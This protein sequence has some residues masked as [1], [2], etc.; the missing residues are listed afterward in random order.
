MIVGSL[1][2]GTTGREEA[3]IITQGFL[4]ALSLETFI[5]ASTS[6]AST[7]LPCHIAPSSSVGKLLAD[8][9]RKARWPL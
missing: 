4:V 3:L 6:S 5:S 8:A 7:P 9:Q 1:K 2:E